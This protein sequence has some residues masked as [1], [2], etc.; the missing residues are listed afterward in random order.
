MDWIRT[1]AAVA[2]AIAT[3]I[4]SPIAG[5]AVKIATDA[6]GISSDKESLEKAILS[7][8]PEMLY[9]LKEADLNF[10]LEAKKLGIDLEKIHAED[11]SSAR[12]LAKV[13]MTP[14][15][16]LSTIYTAGYCAVLWQFVS[17]EVNIPPELESTF[18]V[19]LGVLT[20]AQTQIMNFW[21]GS[22]SGSKDKTYKMSME[23]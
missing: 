1:L 16:I 8:S 7:G 19:I 10:K 23:K 12:E 6:L 9:K 5:L 2:P 11:R 20:A 21:F 18:N 14:Q 15:I 4:G 17:G 22:S 13:N 3:A